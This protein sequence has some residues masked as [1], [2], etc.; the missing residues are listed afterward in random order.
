M[1]HTL[2]I[3]REW[4][5]E[6]PASCH[7]QERGLSGRYTGRSIRALITYLMPRAKYGFPA[8]LALMSIRVIPASEIRESTPTS[9]RPESLTA[10]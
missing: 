3:T 1:E 6:S 2:K 9:S 4:E 8:D 5:P 10:A 7:W